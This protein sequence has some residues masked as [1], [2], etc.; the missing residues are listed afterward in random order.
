[1]LSSRQ[2]DLFNDNRILILLDKLL[3]GMEQIKLLITKMENST[4]EKRIEEFLDLFKSIF[5]GDEDLLTI[6]VGRILKPFYVSAPNELDILNSDFT[7]SIALD[8]DAELLDQ[9]FYNS[10]INLLIRYYGSVFKKINSY[11]ISTNPTVLAKVKDLIDEKTSVVKKWV[12][13]VSR[14]QEISKRERL[15]DEIVKKIPFQ[16]FTYCAH[17]EN[18]SGILESGILCHNIVK[19]RGL[20]HI[21]IS[22]SSVNDYRSYKNK[23]M[24]N[25]PAHDFVNLHMNPANPVIYHFARNAKGR[26]KLVFFMINPHILLHE[27]AYYS[28]DNVAKDP[29]NQHFSKISNNMEKFSDLDW[30][31]LNKPNLREK[32]G[33]Y[34]IRKAEVLIESKI[35]QEY[36]DEIIVYN[37]YSL[38]LLMPFFPNHM[39]IRLK[40]DPQFF[41]NVI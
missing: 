3:G 6:N 35:E 22:D 13:S 36:I 38:K 7:L 34:P 23:F 8:P 5:Q 30:E 32:N 12:I 28:Q 15:K 41:D 17:R 1:M 4:H 20:A 16:A 27:N 31:V 14:R 10:Y 26:D 33:L 9:Q 2:L 24:D 29:K 39:G 19:E 21:D 11:F 18:V 25:R 40:V 37:D